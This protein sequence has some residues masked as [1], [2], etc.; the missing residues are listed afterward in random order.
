MA[1]GPLYNAEFKY[2]SICQMNL[3]PWI[4]SV[5]IR[6]REWKRKL[7]LRIQV[8]SAV[9]PSGAFPAES[10]EQTRWAAVLVSRPRVGQRES[11][12]TVCASSQITNVPQKQRNKEVGGELEASWLPRCDRC[13]L[14]SMPLVLGRCLWAA[15]RPAELPPACKMKLVRLS[16]QVRGLSL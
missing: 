14:I 16:R 12:K 13:S 5:L 2:D 8:L 4:N 3:F 9:S 10:A 7:F 15:L 11:T 1:C 6:H